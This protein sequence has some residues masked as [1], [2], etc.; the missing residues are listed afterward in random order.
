MEA[1]RR[2]HLDSP[3]TPSTNARLPV[4]KHRVLRWA[5]RALCVVLSVALMMHVTIPGTSLGTRTAFASTHISTKSKDPTAET[6]ASVDAYLQAN[7]S[8]T[9]V[10]GASVEIVDANQVLYSTHYGICTGIDQPFILGS[11]SKSFTAVAI[12]QLVEAGE[13]KLD[14][15]L[16]TYLP[17]STIGDLVTI[18]QLLN[19]T[20]GIGAY[21]NSDD[22]SI[23]GSPG[24]FEYSNANY[25]LLGEVISAVTGESYADYIEQN[26]FEP[27]GMSDS[28]VTYDDAKEGG[29]ILG[30]SN[31]F[32]LSI[33]TDIGDPLTGSWAKIPS[34]YLKSS[35]ADMGRYLQMFLSRGTASDGTVVLS[36]HAQSLLFNETTSIDDGLA[37]GM[38]WM[39]DTTGGEL[40]IE[41]SGMVE[42]Y[43]SY[44]QIFP[45]RGIAI[46]MLFDT[47]DSIVGNDL[48]EELE[49]GVCSL[50][51]GDQADDVDQSAYVVEHA[52]TDVGYAFCVLAASAP[53][54]LMRRWHRRTRH[55]L[56]ST[57]RLRRAGV[58]IPLL[59]LH[60]VVPTIVMLLPPIVA[61]P[62]FVVE[63]YS[64][65]VGIVIVLCAILLY[66]GGVAKVALLVRDRKARG[67]EDVGDASPNRE[68][69]HRPSRHRRG[70]DV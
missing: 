5:M 2:Q 57:K 17:A 6:L 45:Q 43:Q 32:G 15:T 24:S 50:I 34:G 30:Y 13:V 66:A 35:A 47:N 23:T 53:T 20:S 54:I 70:P 8:A 65:D 31:Y 55:R 63:G 21:E 37:Y 69:H 29:L 58:A 33:P 10:P 19:Q 46:I 7:L 44:M 22:V 68:P 16:G 18:R 51:E 4:R 59:I 60:A 25:D 14:A 11:L 42:N 1:A 26:I 62:W 48:I 28:Y 40:V 49:T 12:M 56:A 52:G 3:E 64:P 9:H 41:H 61:I 38:G 36:H 27:L 39:I 67:I